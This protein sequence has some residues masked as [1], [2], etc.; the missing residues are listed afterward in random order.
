M[1]GEKQYEEEPKERKNE[2]LPEGEMESEFKGAAA[3]WQR[4]LNKNL[5]YPRE[6]IQTNAQG[7]V[8]IA[9]MVDTEGIVRDVWVFKSVGYSLDKESARL[10]EESP[11]WTPAIKDNHP[12]KSFKIQPIRYRLP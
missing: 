6:A 1:V 7:E 4:Y 12:V 8:R 5:R 3:G 10:L 2:P 9:F 11:A